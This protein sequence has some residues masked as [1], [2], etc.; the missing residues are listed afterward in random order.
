M[1]ADLR[2][3]YFDNLVKFNR[4]RP[5]PPLEVVT[6]S[7][8]KEAESQEREDDS[9]LLLDDIPIAKKPLANA[10]LKF[11]RETKVISWNSK[12]EVII[13]GEILQESDMR[14]VLQFLLGE[15]VYTQGQLDIPKGAITVKERLDILEI[16][17][18]WLK[19]VPR[20][21]RRKQKGRGLRRWIV[22]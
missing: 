8:R 20:F 17:T 10:I 11:M 6:R 3:K 4:N 9:K 21:S 5:P 19:H 18:S 12:F 14:K 1:P 22:Y 15:I 7:E 2:L 16:P 13:D